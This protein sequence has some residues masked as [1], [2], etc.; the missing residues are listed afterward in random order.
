MRRSRNL[1]LT[2]ANPRVLPDT[3]M[4]LAPCGIGAGDSDLFAKAAGCNYYAET[5]VGEFAL[6]SRKEDGAVE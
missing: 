6:G 1:A 4:N 2:R 3:A 5:S